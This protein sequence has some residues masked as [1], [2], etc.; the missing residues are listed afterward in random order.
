MRMQLIFRGLSFFFFSGV[1]IGFSHSLITDR[2]C[3]C[4]SRLTSTHLIWTPDG[5]SSNMHTSRWFIDIL[6][7]M[8]YMNHIVYFKFLYFWQG[9][10]LGRYL[11]RN[12]QVLREKLSARLALL[13]IS[14]CACILTRRI[15]HCFCFTR[16]MFTL[17]NEVI[18]KWKSTYSFLHLRY[19][20]KE[21]CLL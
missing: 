17:N 5:A 6:D 11:L 2:A 18:W 16:A 19:S 4:I 13:Y 9:R 20:L 8:I 3:Q 21:W 15:S 12:K 10:C 14:C 7:I 1:K